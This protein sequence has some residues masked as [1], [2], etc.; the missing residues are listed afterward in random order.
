MRQI[1][2]QQLLNRLLKQHQIETF[3]DTRNLPFRLYQYDRGEILNNI[4]DS[5]H[6]LQFLVKGGVR[7][8]SIREDN[9]CY[10]ICL[11]KDFALLG[12][13]EFCGE[14]AL[15]FFVEATRKVTCIELPLYD[16][17]SA[18]LNDNAFLRFLARSVAHK[19]FLFSQSEAVF[20]NLEERLLQYL[21]LECPEHQF[22]GVEAVAI[23]LHCSRRQL[24]RILKTLT[25][26]NVIE[27]VGKGTYRLR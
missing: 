11:L 15:P 1:H 25:E 13:L 19:L 18:L 17:Q 26:R 5:S 8:Y 2:D 16:C 14:T 24:Q 20:S 10:H 12:D 7:I 23:H 27:K 9:S 6:Y 4:H 21:K 3:F 22:Q